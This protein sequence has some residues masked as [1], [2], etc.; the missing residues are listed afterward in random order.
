MANE[1]KAYRAKAN[2]ASGSTRPS[3]NDSAGRRASSSSNR[4]AKSSRSTAKRSASHASGASQKSQQTTRRRNANQTKSSNASKRSAARLGSSGDKT[5]KKRENSGLEKAGSAAS[6]ALG[7]GFNAIF[8]SKKL[9]IAA[10]V[11]VILLVA[12]I[13]DTAANWGKTYGNVSV[14]GIDVGGMTAEEVDATLREKLATEVTHAQVKIFASEDAQRIA[15][16]DMTEEERVKQIE[17]IAQAEQISVEQATANVQSWSTDALTLKADI[18]YDQL[19]E[20]AMAVGRSNGL[21][22]SR[23]GLFFMKHEVPVNLL[24]DESAVESLASDVDRT[25]G[26]ARIDSTVSIEDGQASPVEGHDGSMVDRDWLK[27]QLSRALSSGEEFPSFIAK[28]SPAPSRISY[29]D[30]QKTSDGVNRALQAGA[31]FT[32]KDSNWTADASTIGSWTRVETV[33]ADDG[34]FKLAAYIDEAE[35]IPSV[36]A[37]AGAAIRSEQVT[38]KF[39]KA[40]DGTI[41]A[42]T[43]GSGNIP[44]VAPAIQKLSEDLYGDGGVAW[45]GSIT[46]DPVHIA[47]SETDAPVAL[48]VDQ[49]VEAGIITVIGEY[50]TEFSNDEGTENRNHNIKLCADI[51]DNGIIQGNGGSWHFNDRTGDTN[52]AAGFWSAGSII[53]GEYVDSVGGGICQVATTV[54][55]AVFEAGLPVDMRFP[56]QL[57]IASY[58]NGR[59]AAV[60]Y[61]DLDLWWTNDLESDILLDMSYTDTTVTAKLYSVYTG[62]TIEWSESGFSEGAG[63]K[64]KFEEDSD[65]SKDMW[66]TKT[67]GVNGSHISVYRTVKDESGNVIS[68][69][70]FDSTYDAKDEV[71]VVGPG[72]DTKKVEEEVKAADANGW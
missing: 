28:V 9:T 8:S 53:Q 37:G 60:S 23:L 51:L 5:R 59:D 62:R 32:F 15:S 14:A 65:L 44:E 56:H 52:E 55:N 66:Y 30:A 69:Q 16:G 25:I 35:A 70:T 61:P 43:I 68:D 17:K 4:S 7:K 64:I 33:K 24:Y 34:S 31:V 3:V 36:V 2:R 49:A 67:T 48:T 13:A 29:A 42:R 18:P 45:N 21:V 20:E 19:V 54:F 46:N 41:Y 63:Y 71:V 50:T 26:D 1:D 27:E 40:N 72:S 39:A 57:Y 6:Q 11:V 12:G 10:L 38:V 58:P 22:F 47:I